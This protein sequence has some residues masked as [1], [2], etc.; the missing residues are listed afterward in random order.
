MS[1]CWQRRRKKKSSLLQ[2]G[3]TAFAVFIIGIIS[4]VVSGNVFSACS[5]YK[6]LATIN[7]IHKSGNNTRFLEV[8]ILDAN[9]TSATYDNW[10]I[11]TCTVTGCTSVSLSDAND[12]D[13]PYLVIEKPFLP[14]RSHIPLAGGFLESGDI[15]LTDGSGNTI[16]YF[17]VDDFQNQWWGWNNQYDASCTLAYDWEFPGTNTHTIARDPDGTG[18]WSD[19][20]GN[21]GGTTESATNDSTP[22]PDGGVLEVLSTSDVTVNAGATATFTVSLSNAPKTYDV[23][24]DYTTIDNTAV[25]ATDYT[26]TNGK[27]SI[28]G[29][30][31]I[32][33][34]ETEVT[35]DVPTLSGSAG[36]VSFYFFISSPV[37]ATIVS[38]VANG[39][40]NASVGA[41]HF[42]ILHDKVGIN[43]LAEPITVTAKNLDG[44]TDT[45]YTGSITLDTQSG[46]GTW[47]LNSGT[48]ANFNDAAALDGLATYTFAAGDN[49]VAVFDL[50]YQ[51]GTSSIDVDVYAG[52]TRDDDTENNLVFS[53]S[54][55]T[56]TASPLAVPFLGVVNTSIPG[57][58]AATNFQ[59]YL[60][61][62]GTTPTDPTCGI[63]EAYDGGKN[64]KFWSTY[65]EPGSGT[66]P[67]KVN[68]GDAFVNEAV[69]AGC[70]TQPGASIHGQ[71]ANYIT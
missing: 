18:D 47:S 45:T 61:A 39:N 37:S 29:T 58:T 36:G 8:K 52:A 4:F 7:E 50:D 65:A 27:A 51:T 60:A 71:S 67:V 69:A 44:T 12:A 35:V 16:D 26:A 15:I 64:L 68:T 43:C 41:D 42:L 17:S 3:P 34:G 59:L 32:P 56:V 20:A 9:I 63:I 30:V 22:P 31:T 53:P 48:P 14:D 62:Y 21:S 6:Y 25:S 23:S 33:A 11:S 57:Q 40:I 1:I 46:S 2:G 54:G 70:R 49:G 5:S 24:F 38:H 55:F 28:R 10:N 19:A 13:L 66:F